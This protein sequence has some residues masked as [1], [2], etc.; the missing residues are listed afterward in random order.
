MRAITLFIVGV[1][2]LVGLSASA[3]L[4][5]TEAF[6]I[7]KSLNDENLKA[8]FRTDVK[9]EYLPLVIEGDSGDVQLLKGA[10]YSKI[11]IEKMDVSKDENSGV[12]TAHLVY[13]IDG[14]YV[15]T[16]FFTSND[17]INWETKDKSLKINLTPSSKEIDSFVSS[18]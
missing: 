2:L 10:K 7:R 17:F 12:A 8:L 16:E 18:L 6:F 14:K 1:F 9:G 15:V 11:K 13:R 5:K 4:K 3:K